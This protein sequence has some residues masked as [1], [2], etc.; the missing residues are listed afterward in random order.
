MKLA[1]Q[2]IAVD[3]EDVGRQLGVLQTNVNDTLARV[4][5]DSIMRIS[6]QFLPENAPY[7]LGVSSKEAI[8]GVT[9]VY[10][11]NLTDNTVVPLYGVNIDWVGES[12]GIKI[13]SIDGLI[14]GQLYEIRLIAYA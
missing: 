13:R 9:P 2:A 12:G 14:P 5:F 6:F 10:L 11:R 4:E 7:L 8:F 1:P 3:S